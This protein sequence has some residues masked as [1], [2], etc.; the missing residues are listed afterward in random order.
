M[1][2][3]QFKARNKKGFSVAGELKATD[4]Y[5]LEKQLLRMG[6]KLRTAKEADGYSKTTF[7][8]YLWMPYEWLVGGLEWIF[9]LVQRAPSDEYD[10]KK[11]ERT[12]KDRA[13]IRQRI[14]KG[15][16][17]RMPTFFYHAQ[18]PQGRRIEGEMEAKNEADLE[19]RLQLLELTLIEGQKIGMGAADDDTSRF[20]AKPVSPEDE[21]IFAEQLQLYFKIEML[22]SDIFDAIRIGCD[23][24]NLR[25]IVLKIRNHLAQGDSLSYAL[26]DFPRGTFSQFFMSVLEV[27]EMTGRLSGVLMY[28]SRHLRWIRDFRRD[29]MNHLRHQF[30]ST[31]FIIM[32]VLLMMAVNISW[33]MS[34]EYLATMA[35][36]LVLCCHP[37][38]KLARRSMYYHLPIIGAAM[39]LK[40]VLNFSYLFSIMWSAG[41]TVEQA[42]AL[43]S[44]VIGNRHMRDELM[45]A[46]DKVRRGAKPSE[47]LADTELFEPMVVVAFSKAETTGDFEAALDGIYYFY[48]HRLEDSLEHLRSV[49]SAILY[50]VCVLLLLVLIGV[51]NYHL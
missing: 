47:A 19:N 31:G 16:T 28:A 34:L 12:R 50:G 42:I 41:I 32:L 21:L 18:T 11:F 33:K 45:M 39:R 15:D 10:P 49:I 46:S 9:Q 30:F 1:P 25:G 26:K 4:I 38:F 8:E 51:A 5:D 24:K 37:Y 40:D 13:H 48:M 2:V 29:S 20:R 43:A 14:A 35:L 3:F 22:P 23:S 7:F 6:L 44:N 27:G 36:I 17:G